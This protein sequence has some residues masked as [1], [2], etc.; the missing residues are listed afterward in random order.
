MENVLQTIGLWSSFT[1]FSMH[2]PTLMAIPFSRSR[3]S[4]RE[5]LSISKERD[6]DFTFFSLHC[7]L[8][9]KNST[10]NL[11]TIWSHF[12]TPGHKSGHTFLYF[13]GHLRLLSRHRCTPL[14]S[15]NT[16][17]N[18]DQIG[19]TPP[20]V[21]KHWSRVTSFVQITLVPASFFCIQSG[22]LALKVIYVISMDYLNLYLLNRNA[23][24]A[25]DS[26]ATPSP[27]PSTT[28]SSPTASKWGPYTGGVH[29]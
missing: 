24:W 14:P 1:A 10:S 23:L 20:Q 6:L 22:H 28:S 19:L 21:G 25:I 15:P 3:R 7:K 29:K 13:S 5:F 27:I 8:G 18:T 4:F 11:V 16:L 26:A 17:C 2:F 12:T 9:T